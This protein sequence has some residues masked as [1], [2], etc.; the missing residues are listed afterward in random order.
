VQK[1]ITPRLVV[2]SFWLTRELCRSGEGLAM[3]PASLAGPDLASERLVRVLPAVK[4]RSLDVGVV[5]PSARQTPT[6]VRVFLDLLER[7]LGGLG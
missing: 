7:G 2:N 6:K 1:S 4:T 5:T 3:L